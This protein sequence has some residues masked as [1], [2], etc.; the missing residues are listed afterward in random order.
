[1]SVRVGHVSEGL[2]ASEDPE[3]PLW[4]PLFQTARGVWVQLRQSLRRRKLSVSQFWVLRCLRNHQGGLPMG[5]LSQ[6]LEVTVPTVTGLV[7]HLATLR[8]VDRRVQDGDRRVVLVEITPEGE[9]AL[10]GIEGELEGFFTSLLEMIPADDRPTLHRVLLRFSRA[11]TPEHGDCA[12]CAG[13][14][15]VP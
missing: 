9:Q 14:G 6:W 12:S 11:L 1:M 8:L 3:S 5:K 7:D 13:L 15:E 4:G 10:R 2:P